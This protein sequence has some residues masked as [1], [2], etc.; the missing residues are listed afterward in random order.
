MMV[1]ISFSSQR[2]KKIYPNSSVRNKF[3][4][5]HAK[6]CYNNS[7]QAAGKGDGTMPGGG[8]Y[9]WV[10]LGLAVLLLG[11][12]SHILLEKRYAD[13]QAERLRVDGIDGW[14]SWDH[15]FTDK[16]KETAVVIKRESTF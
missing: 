3:K 13:G 5:L 15:K 4:T 8:W 7:A 16:H 12:C 2:G 9:R 6:Y 14:T 1:R 10:A 11:G